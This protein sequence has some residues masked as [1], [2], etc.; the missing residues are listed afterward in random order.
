[1][2]RKITGFLLFLFLFYPLFT[3][4][5]DAWNVTPD[6]SWSIDF[7]KNMGTDKDSFLQKASDHIYIEDSD[8]AIHPV[9]LSLPDL[10]RVKVTPQESYTSGRTYTLVVEEALTDRHGQTLVK[11]ASRTFTVQPYG[12]QKKTFSA[13][14]TLPPYV[15]NTNIESVHDTSYWKW[16]EEDQSYLQQD[17]SKQQLFIEMKDLQKELEEVNSHYLDING[18]HFYTS[19]VHSKLDA[20][21]RGMEARYNLLYFNQ[22]NYS[23]TSITYNEER[24]TMAADHTNE[25]MFEADKELYNALIDYPY[26]TSYTDNITVV[27]TPYT[28]EGING[29]AKRSDSTIYLSATQEEAPKTFYH[30][31]GHM[32]D[33]FF[34]PSRDT[35]SSIRNY[36]D[37]DETY[38]NSYTESFAEDFKV[39]R[40]PYEDVIA[41]L[42][43]IGTPSEETIKELES[44]F[45]ETEKKAEPEVP[46]L[47][48]NGRPHYSDIQVTSDNQV[49]FSGDYLFGS[50]QVETP[51]GNQDS[52][53]FG[54]SYSFEK[55]GVY[56]FQTPEGK[57]LFLYDKDGIWSR[58]E[59]STLK[60][61]TM[62]QLTDEAYDWASSHE[63]EAGVFRYN[64]DHS[65]LMLNAGYYKPFKITDSAITSE[66]IR[67]KLDEGR[68]DYYIY[69]IPE[70]LQSLPVLI[71]NNFLDIPDSSSD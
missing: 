31:L 38:E 9:S 32:F 64:K 61:V 36:T 6:K 40:Y 47:L 62:G 58:Q 16:T 53:E 43:K 41:N 1:M 34:E 45:Q 12:N 65:F 71:E 63:F 15:K 68:E 69:A 4:A 51:D 3:H 50:I 2:T 25:G 7:N 60:R 59:S 22:Y 18:F 30:E 28:F 21:R 44:F 56:T 11:E 46:S 23:E 5:E 66:E 55:E 54:Q 48:I 67:L 29:F 10:D 49:T 17:I 33:F 37:F 39:V 42:N 70:S 14:K 35:Y 52:V 24:A 13:D 57:I 26:A 8:G 19:A 27:S 20:L